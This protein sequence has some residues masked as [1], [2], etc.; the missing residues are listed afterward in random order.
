MVFENSVEML[1]MNLN[2]I[3]IVVVFINKYMT[4][5]TTPPQLLHIVSH[6]WMTRGWKKREI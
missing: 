4:L 2:E 3:N 5:S 1:K 6:T